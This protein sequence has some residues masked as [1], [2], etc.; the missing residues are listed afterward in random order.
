MEG[1]DQNPVGSSA[2]GVLVLVQAVLPK[3]LKTEFHNGAQEGN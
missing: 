1:V 2:L 3:K